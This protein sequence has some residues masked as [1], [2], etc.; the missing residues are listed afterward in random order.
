MR[1]IFPR[2]TFEI[3][4]ALAAMPTPVLLNPYPIFGSASK[5][6]SRVIDRQGRL[7]H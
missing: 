7:S 6:S 4:M 5:K 2:A 1:E 3:L